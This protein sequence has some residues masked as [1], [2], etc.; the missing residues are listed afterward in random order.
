MEDE[1]YLDES[2]RLPEVMKPYSFCPYMGYPI[3]KVKSV[4]AFEG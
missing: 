3:S 4:W 1:C 2:S